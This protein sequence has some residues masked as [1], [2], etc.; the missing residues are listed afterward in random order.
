MFKI[1]SQYV[2]HMCFSP[3]LCIPTLHNNMY[4]IIMDIRYNRFQLDNRAN[5]N[6]PQKLYIIN[7]RTS[8]IFS[9]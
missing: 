8:R 3:R 6:R 2:S 7:M 5:L 4:N 1:D 9:F